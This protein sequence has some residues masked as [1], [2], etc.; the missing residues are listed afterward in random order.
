MTN[1]DEC[2]LSRLGVGMFKSAWYTKGLLLLTFFYFGFSQLEG[3]TAPPSYQNYPSKDL[4]RPLWFPSKELEAPSRINFAFNVGVGFLYFYKVRGNLT[5]APKSLFSNYAGADFGEIAKFAYNKTPLFEADLGV[6]IFSWWNTALT[7]YGQSGVSIE[8]HFNSSVAT[9]SNNDPVWSTFRSNLQLNALLMKC[10]FQN[11]YALIIGSWATTPYM[12]LGV[13]PSWQSWTDI[14]LYEM[15]INNGS[16]SSSVL[17]LRQKISANATWTAEF[18]FTLK[19][20]TPESPMSL[21]I[22]CK[23]IDWG[24]ARQMGVLQ[25]QG[26][27]LGPFEPVSA[28]KVYSFV[29]FIGV[30]FNF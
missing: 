30:Q 1:K 6:R 20:A 16:F 27:K 23:Y 18:G 29:P 5:P 24:Q 9:G 17:S 25:E 21:R 19:P 12:A 26:A 2:L 13:G 8:S 11:P 28:K 22:G 4:S 3:S 14:C 7:Y 10:Y 15:V